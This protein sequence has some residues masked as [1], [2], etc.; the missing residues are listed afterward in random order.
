MHEPKKLIFCCF[1]FQLK[2]EKE[3]HFGSSVVLEINYNR[4]MCVRARS[5]IMKNKSNSSCT[6][7][8]TFTKKNVLKVHL[9]YFVKF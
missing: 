4:F 6:V 9:S 7:K 1:Y 3:F 8:G 2:S 5:S